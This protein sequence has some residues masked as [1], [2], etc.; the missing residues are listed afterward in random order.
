MSA[1]SVRH[2]SSVR[3]AGVRINKSDVSAVSCQLV[4][5]STELN[6]VTVLACDVISTLHR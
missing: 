4:K 5:H 2:S 3:L 1:T 6:N